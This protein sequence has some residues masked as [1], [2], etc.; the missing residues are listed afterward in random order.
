[1]DMRK[2]MKQAQ[3]MQ[4]ELAKAQEEV[5]QMTAEATAGG[6]VVKIVVSGD[7]EIKSV[8]IDP[9]A[10][11]PED[12]EMLEDLVLA[13]ANEALRSAQALGNARMEAVTGGLNLPGF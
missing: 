12:V 13:A 3:K 8:T 7:L 1:M 10:V 5:A 9:A 6:G 11:D 4:V 2:M